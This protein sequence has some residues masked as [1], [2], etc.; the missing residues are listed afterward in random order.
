MPSTDPAPEW[1]WYSNRDLQIG[2][3]HV[4][5]GPYD[6]MVDQEREEVREREKRRLPSDQIGFSLAAKPKKLRRR[7]KK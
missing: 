7:R 6:D 2:G 3:S 5:N 4:W 1:D